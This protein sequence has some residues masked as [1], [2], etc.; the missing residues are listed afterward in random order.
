M[1]DRAVEH[2][3]VPTEQQVF[4]DELRL[5]ASKVTANGC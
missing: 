2:D 3:E 4:S 1:F 5:G